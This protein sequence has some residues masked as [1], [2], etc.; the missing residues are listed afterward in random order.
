ML[1]LLGSC[2]V[3]QFHD[4][5]LSPC[6]QMTST[7]DFAPHAGPT[8][9]TGTYQQLLLGSVS[10]TCLLSCHHHIPWQ[11]AKGGGGFKDSKQPSSN[12]CRISLAIYIYIYI[13]LAIYIYVYTRSYCGVRYEPN[14][15]PW[16]GAVQRQE[17]AHSSH[18]D[19]AQG[20]GQHH[21]AGR[22]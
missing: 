20:A 16:H 6:L 9:P 19:C 15:V 11:G 12:L 10:H 7:G 18:A 13:S 3:N 2:L 1:Q 4:R 22:P 14:S 5:C 17:G 21:T 8:W